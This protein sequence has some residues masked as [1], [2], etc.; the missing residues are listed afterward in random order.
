MI[1]ERI[2]SVRYVHFL[3]CD[4]CSD[5]GGSW[6]VLARIRE[7]LVCW[8]Y[9]L[10]GR[11]GTDEH[12]RMIL[13]KTWLL[14]QACIKRDS[15]TATTYRYRQGIWH[16]GT[17]VE[18]YWHVCLMPQYRPI[19]THGISSRGVS[20]N[21]RYSSKRFSSGSGSSEI[22]Q[23]WQWASLSSTSQVLSVS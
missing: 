9:W 12:K 10:S 17:A 2:R 20:S 21:L 22:Q 5:H 4:A 3:D 23:C 14:H 19:A 7:E 8:I 18:L 11:T 6:I 15:T 1:Y 16:I 13:W